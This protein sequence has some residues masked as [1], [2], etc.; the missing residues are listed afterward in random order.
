MDN[1]NSNQD[2]RATVIKPSL[3][4]N[5]TENVKTNRSND[6][7]AAL[8]RISNS[9]HTT[10]NSQGFAKAKNEAN[11]ALSE[12]KIILNNRFV[13]ESTLG[14]GGMG[15]VYKARD[16]RKVEARDLNPYIAVK[17]LN[18]DFRDH[19]D[20]F[21]TLQRE[22]SRSHMLSHPNIVTVH[23]FDRDGN[24][25]YM[26]MEL[27]EGQGLDD[28]L[29]RKKGIGF[30]P[31]QAY[32]IIDGYCTAL[33][34]AHKKN[35]IHSDLKPGNI[36]I[37]DSGVKVLDFGIARITADTQH[38]DDFDAG[39]LGAITPAYACLEMIE[40]QA[41][42]Q[43]DDVY[44]AAIIAYE[45]LTGEH[46]FDRKSADQ[47]LSENL[48]PKKIKQISNRRWKALKSA[49][50]F[51]RKDRTSTINA[52]LT[53]LTQKKKVP[54][55]KVASVALTIVL[56]WFA[57][58]AFYG[59]D[60]ITNVIAE[61]M[62]KGK[63]CYANNDYL[64]SIEN[65][66]IVLELDSENSAALKLLESS[67]R[68]R[69]DGMM[70]SA[71]N[72]LQA[73]NLKCADNA[74]RKLIEM[75]PNSRYISTL[76]LSIENKKQE[77]VLSS[78]LQ[79]AKK[80]FNNKNYECVI[81]ETKTI[82]DTS[83]NSESSASLSKDIVVL[84]EQ[85]HKKIKFNNDRYSVFMSKSVNCFKNKN[86]TCAQAQAKL[87]LKFK[88]EDPKSKKLYQD[89]FYAKTQHNI[90][91]SKV[92]KILMKAE[93]CYKVKNYSCAIAKSE[94]ALEVIPSYT[95]ALNLKTKAKNEITKLKQSINIE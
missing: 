2:D 55:F 4:K 32:K 23:D 7:E 84:I 61:T 67:T 46:P 36:F 86:Y 83:V 16:L 68:D 47:A 58:D 88:P 74:L 56:A 78:M 45:L 72:C 31:E 27:L 37:T 50:E 28:L 75:K 76:Q 48:K 15:T 38:V 54:V 71:N 57:Y 19:P 94:S 8:T 52:L 9:F 73:N 12:N 1:K 82:Q 60:E 42:D 80:C 5:S 92:R 66:K 59:F 25:I 41:P 95:A 39:T 17:V 29:K 33:V 81:T 43:S 53:N 44:A 89:A 64:C 63:D 70:I 13:L 40:N 18:S 6:Y 69:I 20:A 34:H 87:A 26:T 10:N 90:R 22:T 3:K 65:A 21:I 85:S 77:F 62:R 79:K 91:V 30:P 93:K 14:V 24:V 35:I 11:K 49:L 51:R